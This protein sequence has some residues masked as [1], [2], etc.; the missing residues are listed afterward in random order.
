MFCVREEK[1]MRGYLGDQRGG[2]WE[3]AMYPHVLFP[4]GCGHANSFWQMESELKWY[5]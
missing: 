2:L 1:G 3:I 5:V 4:A